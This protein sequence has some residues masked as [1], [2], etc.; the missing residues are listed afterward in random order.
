MVDVEEIKLV[1]G[2][3]LLGVSLYIYNMVRK[4]MVMTRRQYWQLLMLTILTTLMYLIP[5]VYIARHTYNEVEGS[6]GWS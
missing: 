5:T 4:N 3:L 1:H 2:A 6:D